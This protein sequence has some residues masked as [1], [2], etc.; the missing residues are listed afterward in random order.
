MTQQ[1]PTRLPRSP[2]Q[3]L[4]NAIWPYVQGKRALIT[5]AVAT[6]VIGLALNW[7]WLVAVGV[8]PLLLAVLPC[9]AMCALGLCMNKLWGK[10]CSNDAKPPLEKSDFK[11]GPGGGS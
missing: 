2:A 4:I 6:G 10:S 7:S 11:D 5:I 8:A 9:A 3:R 1:T